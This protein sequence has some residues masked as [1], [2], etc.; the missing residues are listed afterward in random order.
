MASPVGTWA[1]HQLWRMEGKAVE[2][3]KL[4]GDYDAK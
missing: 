4:E 3:K 2:E 1:S